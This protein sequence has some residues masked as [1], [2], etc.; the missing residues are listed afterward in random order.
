MKNNKR[1]ALQKPR[2][3]KTSSCRG[4]QTVSKATEVKEGKKGGE[5]LQLGQKKPV[6]IL[7]KAISAEQ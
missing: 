4:L 6:E 7:M 1:T 3:N 5:F 2:E